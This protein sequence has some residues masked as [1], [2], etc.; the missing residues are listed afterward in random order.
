MKKKEKEKEEEEGEE[1]KKTYRSYS[2]P[3]IAPQVAH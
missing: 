2:S 3:Y 1:K